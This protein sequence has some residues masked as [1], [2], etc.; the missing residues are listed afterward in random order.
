VNANTPPP[1][2]GLVTQSSWNLAPATT[3]PTVRAS[4][5]AGT[6][7][8]A[9]YFGMVAPVSAETWFTVHR[10]VLLPDQKDPIFPG[11]AHRK[12]ATA[13]ADATYWA[14]EGTTA[15]GQPRMLM[16]KQGATRRPTGRTLTSSPARTSTW[17]W[18]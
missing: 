4:V 9:R 12:V 5:S 11:T 14:G 7:D 15:A 3:A 18:T 13:I 17:T 8:I 16:G 6:S 10:R 1:K 2:S